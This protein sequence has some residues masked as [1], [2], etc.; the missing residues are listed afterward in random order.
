MMVATPV[1]GVRRG[2]AG[3][4][5]RGRWGDDQG[6][7]GRQRLR[8]VAGEDEDEGPAVRRRGPACGGDEARTGEVDEGAHA[9]DLGDGEDED[10]E[11]V[12][13]VCC[14]QMGELCGPAAH[15][16]ILRVCLGHI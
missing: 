14:A 7:R 8:S 2:C 13:F 11:A 16:T 9:A 15:E 12:A 3:K 6:G 4:T 10:V 5:R 1:A